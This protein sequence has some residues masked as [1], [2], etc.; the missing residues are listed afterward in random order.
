MSV[1]AADAG[2]MIVYTGFVGFYTTFSIMLWGIDIKLG[3]VSIYLYEHIK[4]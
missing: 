4:V 3:Y 2:F 1:N